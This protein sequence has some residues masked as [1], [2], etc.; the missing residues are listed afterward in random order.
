MSTNLHMAAV[1]SKGTLPTPRYGHAAVFD[2]DRDTITIHAGSGSMYLADVI[3]IVLPEEDDEASI[4]SAP[5]PQ[6]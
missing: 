3:Q 6:R 4:D 2:P 1:G 5:E